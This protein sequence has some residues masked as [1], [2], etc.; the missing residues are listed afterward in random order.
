MKYAINDLLDMMVK[1]GASDLH[2][3]VGQSPALRVDGSISAVDGDLLT[4]EYA[5]ELMR[6]ITSP[7]NQDRLK[8]LGGVD[9]GFSFMD[10]ARFRV[11][12]LRAKGS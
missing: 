4:P 5:E 11:S 8:E 6:S 9:F 12:V 3:Q 7:A 10:R 1:Q 2:I